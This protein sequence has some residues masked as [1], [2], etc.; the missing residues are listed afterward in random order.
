LAICGRILSETQLEI[1]QEKITACRLCPRL[2]KYREQIAR[3][4]RRAYLGW[5]YWGRP[6]PGFGDPDAGILIVGLAPA[7]HGANR[8]GRVFTGDRSGDF[9]YKALYEE[10]FASQPHSVSR[11]DGLTL[12][13]VYVTAAVRCAPPANKPTP[14]EILTCR[15]YIQRE[16]ELLANVKVVIAL[17]KLAFDD[18]LAILKGRGLI[19]RRSAFV[20]GHNAEHRTGPGQPVLISSYHPSQQNTQTG[21]LTAKMF[22]EVFANAK[23]ILGA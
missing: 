13:N 15:R 3:T 6:V 2:V 17:G 16:L 8:T 20:F 9:L 14:R 1:L 10:G 7:A 11:D 12:S 18:Y 23:K 22:R 5:E 19:E 21:K 4:K